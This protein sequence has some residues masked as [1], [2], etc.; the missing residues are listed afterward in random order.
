MAK[1]YQNAQNKW[2]VDD[3]GREREATQAEIEAAIAEYEQINDE[4]QS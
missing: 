1:A 2:V 4:A 3:H